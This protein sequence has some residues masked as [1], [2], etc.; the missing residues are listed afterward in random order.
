MEKPTIFASVRLP[1]GI[2]L[3]SD[4]SSDAECTKLM[5]Y[6]VTITKNPEVL[7]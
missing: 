6:D 4:F 3:F 2:I 5:I 7:I 1:A